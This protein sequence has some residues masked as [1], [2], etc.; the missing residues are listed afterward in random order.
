MAFEELKAKQSASVAGQA[1][2]DADAQA[3]DTEPPEAACCPPAE[4][5]SCCS[6]DDKAACCGAASEGACGCR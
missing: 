4:Q 5:R 1:A 3:A 2:P 6:P